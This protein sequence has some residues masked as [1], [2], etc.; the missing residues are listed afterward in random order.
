[1]RKNAA[2]IAHFDTCGRFDSNFRLMLTC[3]SRVFDLVVLVTTSDLSETETLQIDNVVTIRRPNYG[4]DFYSYRVGLDYVREN[5]TNCGVLLLNSSIVVANEAVFG[6]MLEHVLKQSESYDAVGVTESLQFSWHV[7]SYLLYLGQMVAQSWWFREF[8]DNVQPLNTKLEV[9]LSYE[10]GLSR[11]LA[12]NGVK[13]N[14]LF[15]PDPWRRF[16]AEINWMLVIARKGGFRALIGGKPFLHRREVNWP[17]FGAESICREFGFIKTEVL[18]TNPNAISTKFVK[19]L[20]SPGILSDI[21]ML[22]NDSSS[23]YE[24]GRDGITAYRLPCSRKSDIT[25][26][27]V[28]YGAPRM[29]GVRVAVVLHLYYCELLEEF[30]DYLTAIIEPFDLYITTPFEGDI[31]KIINRTAI[32]AHSVTVVLFENKGRD[33]APFVSLYRS[34]YL[35]GY[36][37]VLKLHSKKSKYSSR[38][39]EWRKQLLTS[40]VGDSLVI[41]RTLRMFEDSAV[42]L[43]GPHK[44]YLDHDEFWG[45]NYNNVRRLLMTTGGLEPSQA[46]ELGFF[47]GSMFWFTPGAFRSLK[48]IPDDLLNFELE[49]GQQDGTLA[50]AI[51]RIFCSIARRAGYKVT[52]LPLGD[53]DISDTDTRENRVPVL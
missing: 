46:P 22:I 41:R 40:L 12:D 35:D 26:R 18:R 48:D 29:K 49:L 1:M 10:I 43:I 36:L 28:S 33:I 3:V 14:V 13:V 7:Q 16:V 53:I 51:E 45:A 4:Y 9:I 11:A 17:H 47:A 38:G 50:H 6:R 15:K 25:K 52:S 5:L 24:T 21:E 20:V 27:M 39:D 32:I 2:V 42:G 30:C 8:F 37:A 19:S 34:G 31:S 44:Y 23:Q